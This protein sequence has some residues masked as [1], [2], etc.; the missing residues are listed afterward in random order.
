MT[1]AQ[2]KQY[3]HDS[4]QRPDDEESLRRADNEPAVYVTWHD[5][6]RFCGHLTAAWNP[7]LPP[8]W[9]A[10]LPSEAEWEK[11]A[12][13]GHRLPGPAVAARGWADLATA[14]HLAAA[15]MA[16]PQPGRAWPWG[17]EFETDRANSSEAGIGQTSAVGAFARGCSPYGC[18]E[19]AG[20]VWEWTRSLWGTDIVKCQFAYPFDLDDPARDN[21]AAADEV[22]RLVRGGSWSNAR[23]GARCAYRLRLHPDNR[24]DGLGFRVVLRSAPVLER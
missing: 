4:G 10:C 24:F 15:G 1:T 21:E 7:A 12:R 19:M 20:N 9:R 17:D 2:W 22:L 8:G 13:G 6:Q 16:N 11:A 5:A 14:V 18:E 23:D 3:L